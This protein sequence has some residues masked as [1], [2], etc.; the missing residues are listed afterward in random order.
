MRLDAAAGLQWISE[1]HRT[2]S[3]E[4]APLHASSVVPPAKV[5]I[6]GQSIGAGVATNLAAEYSMPD[7]LHLD[8]LVLETPF[9]SIRAM[10]AVLYPQKW[11]P[12]KYL[13]PFLRNQLDSLQNLGQI[14]N[15]YMVTQAPPRIFILEAAKDELVPLELSKQLYNRCVELGLPVERKAVSGAFHNDAMFRAEGKTAV[16]KFIAQ[17]IEAMPR[18]K[19]SRVD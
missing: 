2:S 11:L 8:S 17:G 6:W 1:Q 4:L 12:Y 9:T 15:R 13:W 3:G 14:A 16:L 7:N 18:K 19:A 5:L 10:L